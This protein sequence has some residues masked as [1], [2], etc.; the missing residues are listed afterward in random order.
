MR[1]TIT[2][3][4]EDGNTIST[5]I[6]GTEESIRAYYVGQYFNFGDNDWGK[7][8]KLVKAES[9]QFHQAA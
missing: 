3:K 2:V 9:V 1:H 7:K 5:D 8:D 4:F 6:N